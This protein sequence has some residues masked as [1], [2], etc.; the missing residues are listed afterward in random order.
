[1]VSVNAQPPSPTLQPLL[2]VKGLKKY[3]PLGRRSLAAKGSVVKAVD[4]VSFNLDRGQI[5]GLVGES[6]CGKT[7]LGRTLLRLIEPTEGRIIFDQTDVTQSNDMRSLRRRMQ[8]VFQDPYSSLDPRMSIFRILKEP[9]DN[10]M[11]HLSR[12]EKR[13]RVVETLQR[14]GLTADH[15]QAS[16]PRIFR[17][18]APAGRPGPEPD[19]QPGA[20]RL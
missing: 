7:T 9:V 11:G 17:R 8:F 14:V 4:G 6:G 2:T 3:F 10:F 5:L 18:P 12:G 13:E 15:D 16:P 1:M 20:D 19:L